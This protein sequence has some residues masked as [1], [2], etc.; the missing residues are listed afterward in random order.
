MRR[1]VALR[2]AAVE[3]SCADDVGRCPLL[4]HPGRKL[5]ARRLR[6]CCCC[7][8]LVCMLVLQL[9]FESWNDQS[10]LQALP[11]CCY[12]YSCGGVFTV[13]SSVIIPLIMV[14][15]LV[16]AR[17]CAAT[18]SIVPGTHHTT[19]CSSTSN[20]NTSV[21]HART[22]TAVRTNVPLTRCGTIYYLS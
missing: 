20:W 21:R 9:R 19:T 14:T 13:Y 12:S 11:Y 1:Y 22:T 7:F 6:C 16:A 18:E 15:V 5:D 8:G 3:S 17:T 2:S 4:S 10:M